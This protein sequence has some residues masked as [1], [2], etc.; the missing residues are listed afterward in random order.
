MNFQLKKTEKNFLIKITLCIIF[1]GLLIIS[2]FFS[3][4]KYISDII[5]IKKYVRGCEKGHLNDRNK[6]NFL[7]KINPKISIILPIYNKEKYLLKS[8]RSIQNQSLK[9]IEIIFVDDLSSDKSVEIIKKFQETDKRII[10]FKNKENK[11]SFYSKI[12][13]AKLA[14]GEYLQFL[15]PDDFLVGDILRKAYHTA[16]INNYIDIIQYYM[17][18]KK[19]CKYEIKQLK[20]SNYII[21]QPELGV[22]MFYGK[23][24]LSQANLYLVDKLI[25]REKF[26]EALNFIGNEYLKER[27]GIHEDSLTLF[28]LLQV[29]NSSL[30][31]DEIGYYYIT[32][33][34][35]S[36]MNNIK[37]KKKANEIIHACFLQAKFLYFKSGNNYLEKQIGIYFLEHVDIWYK[38]LYKYVTYRF[39]LI[40]EVINLYLESPYF[41]ERNKNFIKE[42]QNKI[43]QYKK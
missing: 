27:I 35:D 13:G 37:N 2:Y 9:D 5:R 14:K 36:T 31:I 16:K 11:G 23:G 1:L 25:K 7:K 41:N 12:V 3:N 4:K 43:N 18:E 19:R 10:L 40:N 28:A 22:Q 26:Y 42:I 20:T 6:S 17:I 30:F 32:D 39:D 29:A 24:I 21:H 38:S 15:D 34:Q 8:L 33:N